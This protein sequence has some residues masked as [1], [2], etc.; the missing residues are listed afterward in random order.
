MDEAIEAA[1]RNLGATMARAIKVL[2]NQDTLTK[3]QD[4]MLLVLSNC[5]IAEFLLIILTEL[6]EHHRSPIIRLNS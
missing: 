1:K 5:H 2:S 4:Q 6:I 3:E